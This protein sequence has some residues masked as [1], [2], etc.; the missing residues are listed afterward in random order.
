MSVFPEGTLERMMKRVRVNPQTNCWEYTGSKQGKLGYGS[1]YISGLKSK[2]MVAHRAMWVLVHG[3]RPDRSQFVCHR[4]DNP[5]CCNPGHLF[6]GTLA[7]NNRDMA[8]KGRYNHQKRTHCI[9]G[10]EFTPENTYR[11][12]GRPNRR[13]C[14]ACDRERK[15]MTPEQLAARKIYDGSVRR[16]DRK[17]LYRELAAKQDQP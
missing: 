1:V 11:P 17:K 13:I 5:V 7:D 2:H 12:P 14:L 10:H 8:S 15:S 4:C 16:A 6:L 9:H 3:I